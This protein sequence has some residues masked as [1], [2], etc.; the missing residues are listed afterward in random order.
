MEGA[1]APEVRSAG[2]GILN[3]YK[4]VQNFVLPHPGPKVAKSS[5]AHYKCSKEL[6]DSRSQKYKATEVAAKCGKQSEAGMKSDEEGSLTG[7]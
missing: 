2:E 7:W 3:A 1:S 6:D 5:E 4:R